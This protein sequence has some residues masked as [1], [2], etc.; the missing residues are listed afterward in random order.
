MQYKIDNGEWIPY[1]Q[2]FEISRNKD[3][4]VYSRSLNFS[5]SYSAITTKVIIQTIG[6]YT[7]NKTDL[8]YSSLGTSVDFSRYYNSKDNS[9]FFSINSNI[10]NYSYS[11]GTDIVTT[12]QIKIVTMPDG[13][14]QQ[15]VMASKR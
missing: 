11:N 6:I 4:A 2:P 10:A 12:S 9:W 13:A 15:F 1:T 8:S 7:E 14:K 5:G 3:A